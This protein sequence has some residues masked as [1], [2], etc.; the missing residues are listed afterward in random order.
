MKTTTLWIVGTVLCFRLGE[1]ACDGFNVMQVDRSLTFEWSASEVE[2]KTKNT[3]WFLSAMVC[4]VFVLLFYLSLSV[5]LNGP[6]KIDTPLLSVLVQT[7][8]SFDCVD[9]KWTFFYGLSV[10]SCLWFCSIFKNGKLFHFTCTDSHFCLY[11]QFLAR[12][13]SCHEERIWFINEFC[14]EKNRVVYF[15]SIKSLY[16]FWSWILFCRFSSAFR[17]AR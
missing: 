15:T 2:V 3:S 9:V 11:A 7:D 1:R 5:S 17:I 10:V 16:Y 13:S 4:N 8:F 6:R 14:V 12:N